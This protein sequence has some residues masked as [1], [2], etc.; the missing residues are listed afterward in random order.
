MARRQ[1]LTEEERRV[2]F[3]VPMDRDALVRHYTLTRT[4]LDLVATRRGDP[5]RLGFAVQLML[6]RHPGL[7]LAQIGEPIDALADWMAQTQHS[8]HQRQSSGQAI[9]VALAR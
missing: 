8:C 4:D 2:V 5:N 7:P 1:L 3:G 9:G 6:L